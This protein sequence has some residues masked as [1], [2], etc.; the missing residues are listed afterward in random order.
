MKAGSTD[1]RPAA[2]VMQSSSEHRGRFAPS[3]TGHLHFGSLVAAVG[4]FLQARTHGGAW[5]VRIDDI[6][7]PRTVPGAADSILRDLD[8]LGLE[9]DGPVRYQS[10]RLERYREALDT[11]SRDGWTFPCGC[12]RKDFLHIYPGTCR[13]GL[14][15]GKRARTHRMRVDDLGIEFDDR[16]QGVFHQSLRDEVGDFV[17]RRADNVYAYH[18]AAVMDDADEGV[19]EIVRGADLLAS[20]PRQIHLQR[21]LGLPTPLYTHLPVAVNGAGQKLSKQTFAEPI[22]TREP[23]PLLLEVLEFLGQ[24]PDSRLAEATLAE[25]WAWALAS[26]HLDTVPRCKAILWPGGMHARVTVLRDSKVKD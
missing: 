9:W 20:T 13:N 10:D 16:V 12:S 19:D 21:C 11:L 3:P 4:S 24:N 2:A 23:R 6:D 26:W 5:H 8:R 17:V 15:A 1:P 18:L 7:G 25:L 14:P 22:S